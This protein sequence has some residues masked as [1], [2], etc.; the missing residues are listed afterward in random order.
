[1]TMMTMMN[2]AHQNSM[3]I[4]VGLRLLM[5]GRMKQWRFLSMYLLIMSLLMIRLLRRRRHG[6]RK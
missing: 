2:T 4:N 1:M 3:M 6:M 5:I